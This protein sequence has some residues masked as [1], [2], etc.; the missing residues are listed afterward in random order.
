[1]AI[2]IYKNGSWGT[3]RHFS[4]N[5]VEQVECEHAFVSPSTR[6]DMSSLKWVQGDLSTSVSLPPEKTVIQVRETKVFTRIKK[7][8]NQEL[9]DR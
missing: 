7:H 2:N 8:L 4:L 6:G 1:M 5:D 9:C 3:Y